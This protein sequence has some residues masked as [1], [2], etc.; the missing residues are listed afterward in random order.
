MYVNGCGRVPPHTRMVVGVDVAR[1][2]VCGCVLLNLTETY[3]KLKIISLNI[4]N[5]SRITITLSPNCSHL[6]PKLRFQNHFQ[7][8]TALEFA[9]QNLTIMKSEITFGL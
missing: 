7:F 4:L 6:G 1:V 2:R 3:Y 5:C 9:D 8:R